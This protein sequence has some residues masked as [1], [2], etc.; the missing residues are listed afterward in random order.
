VAGVQKRGLSVFRR[1]KTELGNIADL[2]DSAAP[3]TDDAGDA[4]DPNAK[5]D[6]SFHDLFHAPTV[7]KSK[8]GPSKGQI[9]C[10]VKCRG[11]RIQVTMLPK[12]RT[13]LEEHDEEPEKRLQAEW[14]LA[15]LRH[16][17]PT[18]KRLAGKALADMVDEEAMQRLRLA[19]FAMAL[20]DNEAPCNYVDSSSSDPSDSEGSDEPAD[21]DGMS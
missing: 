13:W 3:R 15:T 1:F 12:L 21:D 16:P 6:A 2:A 20:D 4:L 5:T 11:T 7:Y 8:D 18:I 10:S 14:R 19:I 9:A 17:E